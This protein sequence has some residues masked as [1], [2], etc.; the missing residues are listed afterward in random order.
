MERTPSTQRALSWGGRYVYNVKRRGTHGGASALW[1]VVVL[2]DGEH[3]D[4]DIEVEGLRW[5]FVYVVDREVPAP[6]PHKPLN[7]N[8]IY[9][10]VRR[11]RCSVLCHW[12]Q[13]LPRRV[14]SY[15]IIPGG[16]RF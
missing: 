15:M 5:V 16:C 12:Q 1:F 6:P 13:P 14:D 9:A 4:C 8:A 10:A 3:E 7:Q 11:P 2:M